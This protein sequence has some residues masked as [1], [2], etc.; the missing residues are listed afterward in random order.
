MTA[1]VLVF[2]PLL[3]AYATALLWCWDLWWIDGGYYSHGLL[4]PLLAAVVLWS[5]RARWRR[6][7]AAAD[8]RGWWLLGPALLLHLCGAALTIDSL[9]AAS[10]CLAVPGAAW[11]ALGRERLRGL[12][13]VLW[14]PLL[15]VPQ[16]LFVTGRIAF[17]LKEV[18]VR[19][20]LWLANLFGLG[21]V[22]EGAALR[23]PGQAETLLVADPC[24]GLRSLLAMV[25]VGYA[26]A[27]FA[28]PSGKL[29]R[30]VLLLLAAPLA[31]L[32]NLL[33]IAGVCWL[34]WAF[35]T[36]FA[37]GAGH[38]LLNGVAWVVDLL[39]ILGANEWLRRKVATPAV[40]A[41]PASGLLAPPGSRR[42]SAVVLW[43]LAPALLVLSLYRPF[44]ESQGHARALP[45]VLGPF[46][47]RENLQLAERHFEL[48]GTR[49]VAWRTYQDGDGP[50]V[51]VIAV[52]HEANWKSVH[53]P[54]ICLEGSNMDITEDGSTELLL[55]GKTENIGRIVTRSRGD[56]R[57]YVS[58]YVF[59][60]RDLCTG[61]YLQ[62]FLHH[63]PRALLRRSNAGFLLRVESFVEPSGGTT[64]AEV[65]CRQLL[66][67]L[68]PAARSALR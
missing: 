25:M 42:G 45:A 50:E 57:Q 1:F 20:G 30:I 15:G 22:R 61:S 12:W 43:L 55:D 37:S 4:V 67:T 53:P 18:A 17:E 14:L 7:P 48:L 62:F 65:R 19:G 44:V 63:A 51:Y 34:A 27:F 8:R 39:L 35:G 36:R 47:Q 32:V 52:F 60:S 66:Q 26:I 29:R 21:A 59:A 5:T 41:A 46:V 56:G 68:L 31:L 54:H 9:S 24:G 33:R 10:L 49:D 13:S 2:L 40:T 64:A 6:Q 3:V 11:L 58:L 28:G 16:P 38:D 23:V